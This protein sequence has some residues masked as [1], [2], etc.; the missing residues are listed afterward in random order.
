MAD[1]P[2]TEHEFGGVSTDLKLSIVESYLSAFVTALRPSFRELIYIDAFAGTGERTVRHAAD[3]G[4]LFD[5][6]TPE[7]IERLRGSAAIAIET[8]PSFDQLTF[9][10]RDPKHCRALRALRD[11]HP[12]RR[13]VVEEGD[14][15]TVLDQ[16]LSRPSWAGCRGVLFLDPYGM[17]VPWETLEAVRATEA[18]DVWYLVSLAGLFNLLHQRRRAV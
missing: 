4:G 17:S 3:E 7:R 11:S 1:P 13:I 9:I 2:V 18:L 5:A 15:T 8:T 12:E 14:A 10:D 6:S 16:L